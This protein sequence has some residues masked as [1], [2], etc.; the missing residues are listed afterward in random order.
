[1]E[2]NDYLKLPYTK[3]I[4]EIHEK[5]EHYFYGKVLELEGCQSTGN[6]IQ[7]V[8]SNLDEAMELYIKALLDMKKEVPVPYQAEESDYSGKFVIRIPK[9]LHKKLATEAKSEN[10]SLNQYVVQK[11]SDR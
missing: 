8:Y 5:N 4:R 2:I 7:E 6:T 3:F 10:I 1:M 9:S 11:L